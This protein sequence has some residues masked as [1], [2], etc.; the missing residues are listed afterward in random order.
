[1]PRPPARAPHVGWL[2]LAAVAYGLVAVV[3]LAQFGGTTTVEAGV[4]FFSVAAV[5]L[6]AGKAR[7][8]RRALLQK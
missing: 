3:A 4:M 6:V 5:V 2:V 1:M 7:R 8:S